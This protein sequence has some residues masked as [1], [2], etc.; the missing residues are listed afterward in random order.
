VHTDHD[1]VELLIR[2][3]KD[4]TLEQERRREQ[5][6]RPDVLRFLGSSREAA[7]LRQDYASKVQA[8]LGSYT[9]VS[10]NWDVLA[11]AMKTVALEVVGPVA[12]RDFRPWFRGK[13]RELKA[14]ESIVHRCEVELR[15]ARRESDEAAD[16]ALKARREANSHLRTA[17]RRWE[18]QWWDDLAAK[19]NEVDG[20]GDSAAFWQICRQLGLRESHRRH[21]GCRATVANVE[22]EREAWKDFLS[23]IQAGQGEVD[24]S[25]WQFIPGP[26]PAAPALSGAPSKKEFVDAL[27]RMGNRKRGGMDDVP[28]ELVRFGGDD[29]QQAVFETVSSMWVDASKA[30]QGQEADSWPESVT[31]GVCIPMFKNKGCRQDKNNYRNLVMLS[32]AAKLMARIAATRLNSW[33]VDVLPEEQNGFRAGRGID[34]VHQLVR[35]VLEEVSVAA[36]T[37]RIGMTCFDI[38]R[39]YTRVCRDALWRLM[40]HLGVP[41]DFLAVLR[42]LHEHT[43]FVAF[44]HNG[45][46]SAWLTEK[47]LREGCP[48]SPVL[49]S[50]FHHAVLLTFR[51]RRAS[52]AKVSGVHPGLRWSYKVD[53]HLTRRGK[54][55]LSSRGVQEVTLG[56]VEFADD[57]A[58]LGEAEELCQAEKLFVQTLTD[59]A[60]ME[61][62]GK[63]EKLVL[64]PGGRSPTEVLNEFEVK[65]LKHLGATLTDTGDQWKE[66]SRR[67]QA[68]FFAVRRIA[69]LWSLG[70]NRGRGSRTGLSNERKLRVMR[71]VLEGTLLAC[72]KSRVWSRAQERKANQVLAR[73]IRRALGLDVFNMSEHGYSDLAL[74]KMVHWDDFSSLLHRQVLK[75]VGH[76]A[77]MDITR[78]PKIAL[79]GWPT[80]LELHRSG[81][82]TFPMW[83]QWLLTKHGI[84]T[85]DWFR[86]AQKPTRNWI[87]IIDQALPR[88]R[89]PRNQV[90]QLNAWSPGD[91]L[92]SS[93]EQAN[94]E[95]D[96]ATGSAEP[97]ALQCPACSFTAPT[98]R[99]LQVHY[100]GVHAVQHDNLTTVSHSRCPKCLF[101]FVFAK[102]RF[103]HKCPTMPH[104]AEELEQAGQTPSRPELPTLEC[105]EPTRWILFTD[106]SGGQEPSANAGWGVAVWEANSSGPLPD[107]ELFGP[108][109]LKTWDP[110]WLGAEGASNNVGELT[111]MAEAILWLD[112][113]APGDSA[114][115][116][117][118]HYDSTYAFNAVTGASNGEANNALCHKAR[119]IFVE[120]NTRRPIDFVKVKGHSGNMGNDHADFLAEQGAKGKQTRQSERWLQQVDGPPPAD[121]L[122][123]DHCWRCGRVFTGVSSARGLAGHE[124]YCKVPG[125]P[126]PSIPC[127]HACGKTFAWRFNTG[128]AKQFHHARE[129]RNMHEKVCR[130]TDLLTRTCPFCERAFAPNT[131]DETI[132]KHRLECSNRPADAPSEAKSWKCAKCKSKFTA[133]TKEKHDRECRGSA[134]LNKRCEKCQASFQT[135]EL[136]VKHESSCRGS[137]EANLRCCKCHKAFKTFGSRITHEKSC[138]RR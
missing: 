24:E 126:P 42:A 19:A 4:W 86:L 75:W 60:H 9:G 117:T 15:A 80:G 48:S 6:P 36:K 98:A 45:Y 26:L 74:R 30:H 65:F 27:A 94:T 81:R 49:F 25:V 130:G 50:I 134:A 105:S 47:G 136:R 55:R 69:K 35:R 64:V 62:T 3:G 112:K 68:G 43:R 59:W 2:L 54:A 39:A 120:A 93:N 121:P 135:V 107:Y 92:P 82:Y 124:A 123:T 16:R 113:E 5:A 73:G 97:L 118:I 11:N 115:P 71:C 40:A 111:A 87:N 31:T 20:S 21:T 96:P 12:K 41:A 44:V 52:Q 90:A 76:I 99:S 10:L 125:A 38:V 133:V 34:D 109:P 108:V 95:A 137:L 128:A 63:R 106:G 53:G 22:A 61:H 13:E 33:M 114:V 84:P 129:Y 72:G 116:A 79:F 138:G 104:S 70:S 78:L 18:A 77:R 132:L 14:L 28:V 23:S 91:P 103:R 7:A 17:K 101:L 66:T 56:D 131:T 37:A 8:A 100:D 88:Q 57:T 89:L 119:Q 51:A 67:V 58:L 127:R 122:T 85:M 32:V 29:L 1:P 46:S 83:V 110:R 102:D